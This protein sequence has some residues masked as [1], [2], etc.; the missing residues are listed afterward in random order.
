MNLSHEVQT[1]LA[2]ARA[3]GFRS[4]AAFERELAGMS[5][6]DALRTIKA[7]AASVR[8]PVGRITPAAPKEGP[9]RERLMT[10]ASIVERYG[11]HDAETKRSLARAF[12]ET[13]EDDRGDF[14][15][16]GVRAFSDGR[17]QLSCIHAARSLRGNLG[18][19]EDTDIDPHAMAMARAGVRTV[20]RR[21]R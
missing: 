15:G 1:F 3:K 20:G 16:K 19:R 7:V 8:V 6:D 10:R 17:I 4:S 2:A 12:N 18:P 14:D 21:A 9:M 5:E 11:D 13:R